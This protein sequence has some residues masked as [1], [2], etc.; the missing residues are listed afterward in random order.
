MWF[1]DTLKQKAIQGKD[2]ALELKQK[3]IDFTASKI[4]SSNLVLKDE[5]DFEWFLL[6]SAN[7]TISK[8]DWED[9]I[10]VK[11][12]LVVVWNSEDDFFKDFIL[13]IPVLLAKSFSQS[14]ALKLIDTKNS[15]IDL[16]K[17]NLTQFPSLMV[18]ENKQLYKTIS[19][20][21]N[22][23]KVV[24]NLSLDINKIIEEL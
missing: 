3:S 23:K 9:K 11:R 24:N 22:V 8:D 6:K 7:K 21:E 5:N 18:F 1:L 14:I 2:K 13:S 17:Y 16:K 10:F 20:E 4:S 15:K 19:W 12:V